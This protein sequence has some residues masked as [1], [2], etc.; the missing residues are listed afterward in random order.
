[1]VDA[2]CSRD[3]C[4]DFH[5]FGL[6]ALGAR[7]PPPRRSS[8]DSSDS[9]WRDRAASRR[10]AR[11]AARANRAVR[12][13]AV[14]SAPAS[15]RYRRICESGARHP[16]RPA[17]DRR[18]RPHVAA[19][20]SSSSRALAGCRRPYRVP[21]LHR[22]RGARR[23]LRPRVGVRVPIGIRGIRSHAAR[24]PRGGRSANRAGH[25]DRARGLRRRRNLRDARRC[26]GGCGGDSPGSAGSRKRGVGPR[27]AAG[28]PAAGSRRPSI[29]VCRSYSW[30]TAAAQTLDHLE[31]IARR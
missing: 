5:R 9:A 22:Q 30:D 6:L 18:R 29:R 4:R 31:R 15:R 7:T 11:Q 19:P 3:R 16:V 26:R 23:S 17:G 25:A 8:A 24:S 12:R 2:A 27:P 28:C 20:G 21:Q 10:S 13:V 14:Q 1:M